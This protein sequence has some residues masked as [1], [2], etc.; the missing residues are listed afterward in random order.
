MSEPCYRLADLCDIRT[1]ADRAGGVTVHAVR[2]WRR[3]H[4]E[5]PTPVLRILGGLVFHWP[6]VDRW[7]S[8]T[9]HPGVGG[10]P[11]VKSCA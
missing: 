1:I 7:L 3:L 10:R 5:F 6:D 4:E 8:A 9:G 11:R 2:N